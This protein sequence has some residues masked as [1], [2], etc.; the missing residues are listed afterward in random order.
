MI[1]KGRFITLEGGEGAGKSTQ[2]KK[3]SAFLNDNGIQTVLTREPG[4]SDGAEEIRKLLVSGNK[5]KW[6]VMTEVLLFS[7]ARRNHLQTKILPALREGKWVISDR[8]ADSTMAYQGYGYADNGVGKDDIVALYKMIAKD[9][10]PDLTFILDL[11]VKDGFARVAKR[12]EEISRFEQMDIT[13]HDHLRNAY[14][15]IAK[16]NS[17]RCKLID[18]SKNEDEVFKDIVEEVKKIID[19]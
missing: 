2:A 9:F 5:D 12:G 11:P 8:F 13:F 17:N 10:Q 1:K 15:D 7:A 4:G 16:N 19:V 14:L 3:L 6:D 18:A